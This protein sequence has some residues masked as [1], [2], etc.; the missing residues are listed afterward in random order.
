M[1]KIKIF[2][3]TLRDGEQAPGFSMNLQEKL[4]IAHQ[5]EALNVDVIEA[6]F[7][8]ASPDD[9]EAVSRISQSLKTPEICGLARCHVGDISK[10]LKAIEKAQKPRVHVFI[11]TSDIH[12]E[13]KLKM[14]REQ[15]IEKAVEA[16]KQAK[17]D[18]DRVDFSPEDA[19]RSDR[20]YLVQILTEVIKAGADTINIPDTVG[21][22]TAIEFGDLIKFLSVNVPGIEN[23]IIS[24]HCHNDL[25]MAVAN[26]LEGVRNGAQQIECTINGIGERAGNASL[27][28]VVMA[29]KTRAKYYDAT[30]SINTQLLLSTSKL[31]QS[32][33]G[34][35]VQANKAIV[36]QNA[37]AHEAG[38]HQHG[39]L[40]N[41]ATYEIMKAEDVGWNESSM[42]LGKHSGK[43]AAED[44]LT[45]LGIN[46]NQDELKEFMKKFK[47]LA[48]RKK[49]IYDE[50]L[51]LLTLGSDHIDDFY[52]LEGM[53]VTS[54]SGKDSTASIR[55][56]IGDKIVDEIGKGNGSVDAVL[57]ALSKAADFSGTLTHF[58]IDAVSPETD[59]IA[60]TTI[61]WKTSENEEYYGKG[62]DVD[63][64][65]AC[66]YAFVD[67]LN[68]SRIR[69]TYLSEGI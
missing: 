17:A 63:T 66:A 8:A 23:C 59:A 65:N 67:V 4:R 10:T 50:D 57:I 56:K 62:R 68:R 51:V 41:R 52:Y 49:D 38:I 20:E 26:S 7:P 21:Y 34:Q 15:A 46:L 47:E 25:G 27:E 37:F 2:D 55:L 35:P 32:I 30:T 58:H 48:D 29:L 69:K 9:F 24:T 33:T 12:L 1:K 18:C 28:E 14:S 45:K 3:T 61:G 16:V 19:G 54:H 5:L 44:R 11:A 42:V 64:V 53:S 6:G 13:Y 43:N 36:G 31:L 40:K 60:V 22:L 39:I